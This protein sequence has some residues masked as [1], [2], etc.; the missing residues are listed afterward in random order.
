[1]PPLQPAYQRLAP[2]KC[3]VAA[4]TGLGRDVGVFC[5]VHDSNASLLPHLSSRRAPFTI[6]STGTWV[7]L[8][9]PGLSVKGLDPADD[10]L[11]NVDV[12]GRPVAPRVSWV[13][14]NM[15]QSPERQATRTRLRWR[16]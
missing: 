4:A 10:T 9:A 15:P 12:E 11:A 2:I 16:V 7:I 14:A 5:G 3:D 6:I 1:M 13:D 8:L